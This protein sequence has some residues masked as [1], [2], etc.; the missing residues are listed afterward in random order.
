VSGGDA[1]DLATV[2]LRRAR[3]VRIRDLQTH[4]PTAPAAGFDLDA[5]A[6][7]HPGP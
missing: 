6:V 2:G 3:F 1:F 4:G 7:L 5:I